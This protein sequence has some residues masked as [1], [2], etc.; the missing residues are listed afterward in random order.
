MDRVEQAMS[1]AWVRVVQLHLGSVSVEPD[2][3]AAAAMEQVL[4]SA[5]RSRMSG[6]LDEGAFVSWAI[7]RV[8]W[9]ARALGD[10][11]PP[12]RRQW[13]RPAAP[14]AVPAP[15]PAHAA[16]AAKIVRGD[17]ARPD[18]SRYGRDGGEDE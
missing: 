17:V 13:V 5:Y 18:A 2:P 9:L 3:D 4:E 10:V 8:P 7:E 11:P 16:V 1:E 12:P 14:P 15:T 6:T